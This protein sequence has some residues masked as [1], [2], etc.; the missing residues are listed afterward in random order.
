M[1][2]LT[3]A[4]HKTVGH[5]VLYVP[6]EGP[7]MRRPNVGKDKDLVQRLEGKEKPRNYT[8]DLLDYLIV[9]IIHWTRQIKEVLGGQE[10]LEGMEGNGPLDELE[11]WRAR[12]EDLSGLTKQLD[13]PGVQ[14][15]VTILQQAKSSYLPP[16]LKL[17]KQ[18]QVTYIYIYIYIYIH[19]YT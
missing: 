7:A 2:H 13:Q 1:A 3:D 8:T 19:M 18:I 6:D 15:V 12:C 4:Q 9:I 17:T 16:F 14:Q 11:F 10:S 5:T